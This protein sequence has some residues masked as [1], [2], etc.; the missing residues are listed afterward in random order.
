MTERMKRCLAP[1]P[2]L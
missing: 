1:L 2:G